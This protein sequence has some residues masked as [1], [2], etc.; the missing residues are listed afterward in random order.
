MSNSCTDVRKVASEIL[1]DSAAQQARALLVPF[2]GD[3]TRRGSNRRQWRLKGAAA[4]HPL[5][6]AVTGCG[7]SNGRDHDEGTNR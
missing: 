7:G 3:W 4:G 5:P 2:L 6:L 1:L